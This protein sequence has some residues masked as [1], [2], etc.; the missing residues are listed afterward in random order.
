MQKLPGLQSS[1]ARIV[2]DVIELV[3]ELTFTSYEMIEVVA[4]IEESKVIRADVV[5]HDR[6][7]AWITE[8]DVSVWHRNFGFWKNPSTIVD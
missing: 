8:I 7:L 4:A 1:L 5:D 2:S 6:E 3:Q